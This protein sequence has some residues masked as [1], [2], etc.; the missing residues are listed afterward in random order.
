MTAS[1]R[2][3]SRMA[4]AVN[5]AG[6]TI[7]EVMIA[8]LIMAVVLTGAFVTAN[9][10]LK[11]DNAAE[12]HTVALNLA[13]TQLENIRAAGSLPT[14]D[15]CM[16]NSQS[17]VV[18][19]SVCCVSSSNA[20]NDQTPFGCSTGDTPGGGE[21]YYYIHV[22]STPQTITSSYDP[23]VNIHLTEYTI[24][25]T[26]PRIGARIEK[27]PTGSPIVPQNKV[28]LFYRTSA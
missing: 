21:F 27:S 3:Y 22:K 23:L 4:L 28:Q 1:A 12:Q 16:Q 24:N 5:Q 20:I 6:D 10:S 19:S 9:S 7:I 15:P 26:W 2:K 18:G 14:G 17:P 13:Q 8:L 11:N 25:V